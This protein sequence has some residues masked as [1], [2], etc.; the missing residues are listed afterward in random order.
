MCSVA[1]SD[2]CGLP[3]TIEGESLDSKLVTFVNP[4]SVHDYRIVAT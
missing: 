3:Q 4:G 2:Q 1:I